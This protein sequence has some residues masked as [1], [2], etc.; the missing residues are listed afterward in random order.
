MYLVAR[1]EAAN[2]ISALSRSA[3]P[4]S[5]NERAIP[6]FNAMTGGECDIITAMQASTLVVLLDDELY[7]RTY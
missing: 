4:V 2:G 5:R 6:E 3:K 1:D 7:R